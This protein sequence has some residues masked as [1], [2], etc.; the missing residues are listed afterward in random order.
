[1]T[2]ISGAGP[3]GTSG[4]AA[5]GTPDE[6]DLPRLQGLDQSADDPS[7]PAAARRS[8]AASEAGPVDPPADDESASDPMTDMSGTTGG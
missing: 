1:M 3:A 7:D 6:S 2:E 8:D 4:A 5:G